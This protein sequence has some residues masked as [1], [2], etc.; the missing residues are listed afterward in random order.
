MASGDKV[1][2][3]GKALKITNISLLAVH[4]VLFFFFFYFKVRFMYFFN[5]ASVLFYIGGIFIVRSRKLFLYTTLALAEVL[6]HLVFATV[7]V[8]WEAGFAM[9]TMPIV[10]IAFYMRYIFNDNRFLGKLPE[11]ASFLS[12]GTFLS[13]KLYT[14][15]QTPKYTVSPIIMN[16]MYLANCAVIFGFIIICMYAFTSLIM[17]RETS[18]ADFDELTQLYNRHKMRDILDKAY[19]DSKEGSLSFATAI[20][21]I[22]DFKKVN[23]TFGHD[24]GDYVLRT[25]AEM[26]KHI[27]QSAIEQKVTIGRWGGEEFLVVLEYDESHSDARAKCSDFIQTIIKSVEDY[28]FIYMEN[29]FNLTMTGGL[30]FHDQNEPISVTINRADRFLYNGKESGKN[31]LVLQ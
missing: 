11:V 21:D 26:M 6:L 2:G 7:C 16:V 3:L 12:A 27:G 23:D 15:F 10:F 17:N 5:I 28:S 13:L 22:D 8:G 9:Y 19:A 31:K 25:I 1:E 30:A 14:I 18:L 24:A 29:K 4:T 20:V